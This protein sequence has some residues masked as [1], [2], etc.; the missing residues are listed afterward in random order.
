VATCPACTTS[1]PPDA[2]FC[3]S[4]G[5]AVLDSRTPTRTSADPGSAPHSAV[6]DPTRYVPG[7]V[8]A[9]RYRVIG[10]LGRGGMGEV[11]RADDLKLGQPVALKFLP[12]ALAREADALARFHQEVRVARQLSHPNLCR[13]FDIGEVDGR[14]FLTMEFIDGEDLASLIRRI[15]RLPADKAVELARQLCAGL[16]A[17]HDAGVLHRDLKP[18]NIMIDGRGRARITD[19]GLAGLAGD[20]RGADLASGTPTYMAPEQLAGREVSVRSD[21][22][23]LGL[24]L[25]EMFTGRRAFDAT[26][27]GELERQRESASRPSP[28]SVVKDLDPAIERAIQRCLEPDPARRPAAA[29]A[30]AAALP[31]GD[32]LEA[33]LAAGETPS[34]EMVA[35][36]RSG[37]A[38]SAR[39]VLGAAFASLAAL[40]LIVAGDGAHLHHVALLDRAPVALADRAGELLDSLGAGRHAADRAWGVQP[41]MDYFGWQDPLPMPARLRRLASGQPAIYPFWFRR[42][43]VA[44]EA[45]GREAGAPAVTMDEPPY[46]FAD[47][48]GVVLDARGRLLSLRVVPPAT[49]SDTGP[50]PSADWSPLFAAAALD[51]SAFRPAPPRWTP[52]VAFDERAAWEGELADHPDIPLRVEAAAFRGRPVWFQTITPWDRPPGERPAERAA[53]ERWATALTLAVGVVVLGGAIALARRH[54]RSGSGDI[55]GARRLALVVF[56]IA[57]LAALIAPG[58][59]S[60]PGGLVARLLSALEQGSIQGLLM[61]LGYLALEPLVRRHRPQLL[62][63]W[64]RLLAGERRD[65][66][67]GRELL[68]GTLAGC[69]TTLTW[70]L[71]GW[72]KVWTRSP[73]PPNH[74]LDPRYLAGAGGAI[75]AMLGCATAALTIGL[76]VVLLVAM[77][78][79]LLRSDGVAGAVV[80]ALWSA[81]WI[82]VTA[83]SWPTVLYVALAG[84]LL[85]FLLIR[86]GLLAGITCL[87]VAQLTQRTPYAASWSMWYSGASLSTLILVGLL[88]AYGVRCA[89]AGAARPRPP[90]A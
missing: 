58:A 65:P 90:A 23:A 43:P 75:V 66:G 36:A 80:W 50:A 68:I 79:P 57:T 54:L 35:A 31:G 34:P 18:A 85:V 62:V 21:V 83:R 56:A 82:L 51:R 47:M 22:Y 73:Y 88:L 70:T 44:L 19:F 87:F 84:A 4:C 61:A 78:R 59:H 60:P 10:L 71:S 24:V 55:T 8:L 14:P 67:V 74:G 40:A 11:V 13:V 38:M 20:F 49:V 72:I 48:A 33:A 15:G 2:R 86:L 32:P 17:A 3:A 46:E 64:T 76:A 41:R 5:R 89:G 7:T 45:T 26:D 28:A 42:S 27:P 29:L 39:A 1:V 69:A 12:D 16:A 53:G 25:Y 81:T 6:G 63:G 77:L 9:G 52:P 30:V 37:G